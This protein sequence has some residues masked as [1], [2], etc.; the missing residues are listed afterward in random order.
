LL[1]GHPLAGRQRE[2]L[3]DD[4]TSEGLERLLSR[5]RR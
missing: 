4:E 1:I 5:G 3:V 2:Q